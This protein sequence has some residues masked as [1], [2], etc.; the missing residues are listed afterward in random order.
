MGSTP[1]TDN[2]WLTMRICPDMT[3]DSE[4]VKH[5]NFDLCQEDNTD[6]E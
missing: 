6:V 3:L 5:L 2:L 1:T 4:R